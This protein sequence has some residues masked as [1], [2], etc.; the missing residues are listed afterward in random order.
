MKFHGYVRA[1]PMHPLK[2][3]LKTLF[4]LYA[5]VFFCIALITAFLSYVIVFAILTEKRAPGAAHQVSRI[6]AAVLFIFY[7]IRPETENK[8]FIDKKSTYV[9]VSNHKSLLDIPLFALSCKNTF[10]F[11]A[12]EELVKIPLMGYVI[13]RLYITVNRSD[14]KDRHRSM[15]IMNQSLQE[16][17]SVFICP[18][19]TRNR[20]DEPMLLDFKDGAFRLAIHSGKPLAVFTVLNSGEL[21]SPVKW[22]Q[23]KPGIL[24]GV[25]DKP[26]DTTGMTEDDLPA[27]KEKVRQMM[28]THLTEYRKSRSA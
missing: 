5:L 10:R 17:I 8:Q 4:G 7:F 27:L 11:L 22:M 19:G 6:W 2:G 14:R 1:F 24:R 25:W 26:I 3:F 20:N 12:K 21:L 23:L 13:K 28:I 18:E 16:G 9:F 15:E